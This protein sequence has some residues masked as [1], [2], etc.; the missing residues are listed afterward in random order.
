M[1]T[2]DLPKSLK[3]LVNILGAL[4]ERLVCFQGQYWAPSCYA[5]GRGAP[6]NPGAWHTTQRT[7]DK[8]LALGL[9]ANVGRPNSIYKDD[10]VY[11]LTNAGVQAARATAD[12][13]NTVLNL[14]D[15]SLRLFKA[16]KHAQ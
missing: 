7:V 11:V 1:P 8:A 13:W 14:D 16:S 2:D 15:R 4:D 6:F 3:Y 9:I 12:W 10:A 5:P